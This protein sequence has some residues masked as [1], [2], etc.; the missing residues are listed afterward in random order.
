MTISDDQMRI[1]LQWASRSREVLLR[2]V[3]AKNRAGQKV[4]FSDQIQSEYADQSDDSSPFYRTRK[5]DD[6]FCW[7]KI[8]ILELCYQLRQ[9]MSL[10]MGC[11]GHGRKK[12]SKFVSKIP[13]FT[14]STLVHH[15]LTS[16]HSKSCRGL[17]FVHSVQ[18]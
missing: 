18:F 13:I 11:M 15:D 4:T 16:I 9:M 2:A 1:V 3:V 12:Y 17:F 5:V 7:V 10:D 14:Y 6:G 8:I